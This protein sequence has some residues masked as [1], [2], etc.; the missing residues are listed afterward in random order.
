MIIRY[1]R[2]QMGTSWKESEN[3][4]MVEGQG[5]WTLLWVKL[6]VLF[7]TLRNMVIISHNPKINW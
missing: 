3:G 4:T 7:L 6:F 1:P 5:G 2:G